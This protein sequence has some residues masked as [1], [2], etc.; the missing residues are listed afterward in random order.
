[1]KIR[2]T[3]LTD[4][5][6]VMQIYKEAQQMMVE[7]QNPDQWAIGYPAQATIEKDIENDLSYVCEDNGNIA[8]VF[9]FAI[10]PDP[11]YVKIDGAWKNDEPYGVVH[12]IARARNAKGA[13]AF[14]LKWCITQADN[15]RIDTHKNNTP[16]LKL[17]ESLGFEYCGIIWLIDV[18]AE[19]MSFQFVAPK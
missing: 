1:M 16:M 14:C 19:R 9:Y 4:L 12:R 2:K 13:G 17:L 5:P 18:K 7:T 15:V 3:T 8:A 10:Q 6:T 11:N